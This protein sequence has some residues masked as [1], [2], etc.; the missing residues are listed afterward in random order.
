M[1][2]NTGLATLIEAIVPSQSQ[3][4]SQTL[5][6]GSYY[7]SADYTTASTI[8]PQSDSTHYMSQRTYPGDRHPYASQSHPAIHDRGQPSM[9]GQQKYSTS[10]NLEYPVHGAHPPSGVENI[11]V[12]PS[13]TTS[14]NISQSTGNTWDTSLPLTQ[15]VHG[16]THPSDSS[17]MHLP[18]LSE[19][20]NRIPQ[21]ASPIPPQ[22]PM[23]PIDNAMLTT[24]PPMSYY[25]QVPIADVPPAVMFPTQDAFTNDPSKMQA[26]ASLIRHGSVTHAMM[27]QSSNDSLNQN[28]NRRVTY[29][30][31]PS[32]DTST[33]L[34][35]TNMTSPETSG[36]S[37]LMGSPFANGG[38]VGVN[39][40]PV[41]NMVR[42]SPLVG[43]MD[44]MTLQSAHPSQS[45][46]P[47]S[48][49]QT[50]PHHTTSQPGAGAAWPSKTGMANIDDGQGDKVYSFVPNGANTKKRPRRRFD[51]IERLYVCNWTDCE[52]AYGT[53]NHLNAHVHMQK[54]GPKRSPAGKKMLFS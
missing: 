43:Y 44:A 37:P 39:P 34:L 46:Y 54:H 24:A 2:A 26:T 15:D 53:L 28:Y 45:Q 29:P 11:T 35:M 12:I 31:V 51:E 18:P 30:F 1:F 48:L 38:M 4:P 42:S 10:P 9:I 52:K 16:Q 19:A 27:P 21:N 3:P 20:L 47:Q 13:T 7:P 25:T 17:S 41:Q 23:T 22:Q 8:A 32:I 49:H 50:M 14:I 33:G 6:Q 36:S 5:Y 40:V